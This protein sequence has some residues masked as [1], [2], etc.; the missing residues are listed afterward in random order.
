MDKKQLLLPISLLLLATLGLIACGGGEPE[1]VIAHDP[2][3]WTWLQETQQQLAE[4]R[5]EL[6][7]LNAVIAGKVEAAEDLAAMTAEDLEAKASGL[8][9]EINTLLDD[10]Q[11]R[12]VPFINKGIDADAEETEIHSQALA[13]KSHEDVLVAHEYIDRGGDYS[14][15]INIMQSA[16]EL[17][18]NN[19]ALKDALAGAE[20]NQYMSE[21][22]FNQI[23]KGMTSEEVRELLGTVKRSNEREDTEKNT[24]VWLYKKA[25]GG[26]AGVYFSKKK[27]VW[28]VYG[29]DFNSVKP[30]VVGSDGEEESQG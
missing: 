14:R 30:K 21:E 20:T 15:A 25:D 22:R 2:A 3:E 5:Q 19:Q 11:G 4:K 13:M 24:L 9:G 8:G 23:K 17:D 29:F 1:E 7:D 12:L 6:T 10:F 27:D 26:G 16:L 28:N 18:P